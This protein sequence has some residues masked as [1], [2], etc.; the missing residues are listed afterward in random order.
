M[1]ERQALLEKLDAELEEY[2]PQPHWRTT[3]A[4][5]RALAENYALM[6]AF[7][8]AIDRIEFSPEQANVYYDSAPLLSDMV[9][10][11]HKETVS[12]ARP[13]DILSLATKF[14]DETWLEYN[15]GVLCERLAESYERFKEELLALPKEDIIGKSYQITA[16]D[17]I[18]ILFDT[19]RFELPDIETLLTLENPLEEIYQEWRDFDGAGMDD[20]MTCV[21]H[22]INAA[23][24]RLSEENAPQQPPSPQPVPKPMADMNTQEWTFELRITQEYNLA[25]LEGTG[26]ADFA[27]LEQ[28]YE[29][30]K[31]WGFSDP[32]DC[33]V[34]LTYP[35]PLEAVALKMEQ[36]F[37]DA[38]GGIRL[39]IDERRDNLQFFHDHY[40]MLPNFMQT[41]LRQFEGHC[42]SVAGQPIRALSDYDNWSFRQE[43]GMQRQDADDELEP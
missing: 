30:L 7:R 40:N 8:T 19:H 4:A 35:R 18:L 28:A 22:I 16:K 1:E 32:I 37:T 27:M 42:A 11:W 33:E 9:E 20:L 26:K 14:L 38:E 12:G 24:A 41:A 15:H 23:R 13:K 34:L 39:V 36:E 5:S 21:D 25:L 17:D 31:T 2:K 10:F 3:G 6:T 29:A 43:D